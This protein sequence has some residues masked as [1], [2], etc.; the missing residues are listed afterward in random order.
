MALVCICCRCDRVLFG[1]RLVPPPISPVECNSLDCPVRCLSYTHHQRYF[2]SDHKPVSG[3]F[4]VFI[5]Y[6]SMLGRS[7]AQGRVCPRGPERVRSRE[8]RTPA[9]LSSAAC[10][11]HHASAKEGVHVPRRD[12]TTSG[13]QLLLKNPHAPLPTL[14]DVDLL[15]G[16]VPPLLPDPLHYPQAPFLEHTSAINLL[17]LPGSP[18]EFTSDASAALKAVNAQTSGPSGVPWMTSKTQSEDAAG[19]NH[20]KSSSA[21]DELDALLSN[22]HVESQRTAGPADWALLDL[23]HPHTHL[24]PEEVQAGAMHKQ[25]TQSTE[26]QGK[27]TEFP[28][29]LS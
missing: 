17:S 22:I 10:I 4:D 25:G 24:P 18:R 27:P 2:S 11:P 28:D 7:T 5:P 1:G 12:P 14:T 13:N 8:T 20:E 26:A 15:G 19:R 21:M 16:G 23:A 6:S 9:G 29:L 3:V